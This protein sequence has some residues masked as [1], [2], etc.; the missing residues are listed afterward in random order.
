MGVGRESNKQTKYI[1]GDKYYEEKQYVIGVR[2]GW[3]RRRMLFQIG[4]SQKPQWRWY[5]C[6][7][8][9]ETAGAAWVT[10]GGGQRQGLRP[11]GNQEPDYPQPYQPDTDFLPGG[12]QGFWTGDPSVGWAENRLQV[13][14][15]WWNPGLG[16]GGQRAGHEESGLGLSLESRAHSTCNPVGL[17]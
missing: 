13:N 15:G 10:I 6:R 3:Q 12:A 11:E 8:Q 16:W 7:D 2:E 14:N 1:I 9:L 5:L 17:E 4:W